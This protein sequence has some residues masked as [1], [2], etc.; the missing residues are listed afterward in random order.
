MGLDAVTLTD[1][2]LA[3]GNRLTSQKM[4]GLRDPCRLLCFPHGQEEEEALLS[5]CSYDKRAQLNSR[6][7]MSG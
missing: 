4:A 7:H 5:L 1:P 6:S 2:F 3:V